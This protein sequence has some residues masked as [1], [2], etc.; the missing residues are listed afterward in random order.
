MRSQLRTS[1]SRQR[2]VPRT[3][4]ITVD[5]SMMIAGASL[6]HPLTCAKQHPSCARSSCRV[7]HRFTGG[8]G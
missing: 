6:A 5:A 3:E 4:E 2:L 8:T 7:Y 1:R